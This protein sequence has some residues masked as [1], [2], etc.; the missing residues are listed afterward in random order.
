MV[1]LLFFLSLAVI[2]A[3][4]MHQHFS[5][6]AD[7]REALVDPKVF[8]IV[9]ALVGIS[10]GMVWFVDERYRRIYIEQGILHVLAGVAVGGLLGVG[11]KAGF[12]RLRRTR[13]VVVVLTLM[14]LGGSIG[15]PIGWLYGDISV[16]A[17]VMAEENARLGMM[18][19]A[20]IGCSVGLALG[21]LELW[22]GARRAK[23][24]TVPV[25]ENAIS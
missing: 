2:V 3:V 21:V 9:G 23:A 17:S 6:A 10:V 1:M 19:G 16:N 4:A 14:L 13:I 22:R 8:A 20:V 18:W 15:A 5:Q 7:V 25:D 24:A 12:S 11:V